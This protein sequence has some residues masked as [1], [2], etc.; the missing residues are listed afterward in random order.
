L[1]NLL[2]A[3]VE[4][5]AAL[6]RLAGTSALRVFAD[7]ALHRSGR[8]LSD[9]QSMSGA[10]WDHDLPLLP[11]GRAY[12]AAVVRAGAGDG[13]GL[14]AHAYVRYF[15]DLSGG[16]VLKRLLG[17]SLGLGAE[18]LLL[19]DFPGL[20]PAAVKA[21][22]RDAIDTGVPKAS[23]EMVIAEAMEA[24]RHNIAVSRAIQALMVSPA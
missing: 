15:G 2:P 18:A 8:I 12:A 22:M 13:F 5:E 11:A 21:G 20:D 14:M 16:Q 17:Q 3:Y 10:R 4:L 23:R 7:P 9:I 24:F 6:E 19:Y 1:R